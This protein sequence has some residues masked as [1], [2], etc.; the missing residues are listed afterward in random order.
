MLALGMPKG[1]K[2]DDIVRSCTELGVSAFHLFGAER[3]VARPDEERAQRRLDRLTRVA[4]E[5]ARQSMRADVPDL[6]PPVSLAEVVARVP[7]GAARLAFVVGAVRRVPEV[8]ASLPAVEEAW[9]VVGPEGG[10]SAAE[11]RALEEHS[12]CAVGLGP[13][14][15]RV[16]TAAPV[17]VAVVSHHLG[18]LG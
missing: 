4:R 9:V 5:A 7:V 10:L 14:V 1:S 17:A 6:W 8:L 16:E 13:T 12:F 18:A 15:L 11:V 3:S 2:L